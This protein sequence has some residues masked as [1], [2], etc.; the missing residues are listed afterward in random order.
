MSPAG[1]LPRTGIGSR[2]LRSVIEYGLPLP[3][4]RLIW[5]RNTNRQHLKVYRAW[6]LINTDSL[7]RN[8]HPFMFQSRTDLV[9]GVG[10]LCRVQQNTDEFDARQQ[11]VDSQWRQFTVEVASTLLKQQMTSWTVSHRRE[12]IQIP[13]YSTLYPVSRLYQVN[14]A[15]HPSGVAKSSTSFGWGKG[16]NVTS[17]WSRMACE[18]P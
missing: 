13:T 5:V 2:T 17:V 10:A 12:M 7:R 8:F 4:K 11:C 14:S 6:R 9:P 15:L 16:G 18:F 3:F 1:W